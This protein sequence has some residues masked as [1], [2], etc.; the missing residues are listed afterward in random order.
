MKY[1]K[2]FKENKYSEFVDFLDSYKIT[3]KLNKSCINYYKA[4]ARYTQLNY[5]EEKQ[6]WDEYKKTCEQLDAHK[7]QGLQLFVE[8]MDMLWI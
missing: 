7:K 3:D 8:H 1:I 2:Y 6:S 4:L 5:L